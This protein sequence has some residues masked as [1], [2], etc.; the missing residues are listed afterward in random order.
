MAKLHN[1]LKF[2]K[3]TKKVVA[4]HLSDDLSE[5]SLISQSIGDWQTIGTVLETVSQLLENTRPGSKFPLFHRIGGEIPI[6]RLEV[7]LFEGELKTI[8]SELKK[9]QISQTRIVRFT[10]KGKV[11]LPE[12][13]SFFQLRSKP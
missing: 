10:R 2:I 8:K 9:L 7:T 5:I 1:Y 4:V 11:A 13:N 12:N 3:E 6:S